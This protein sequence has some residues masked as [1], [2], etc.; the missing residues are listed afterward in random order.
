MPHRITYSAVYG[1]ALE[2]RTADEDDVV[3]DRI[4]RRTGWFG[5]VALDAE[6]PHV[7][8]ILVSSYGRKDDPA[9][10]GPGNWR[11][12]VHF[13]WPALKGDATRFAFRLCTEQVDRDAATIAGIVGFPVELDAGDLAAVATIEFW[14]SEDPGGVVSWPASPALTYGELL[15]IVTDLDAYLRSAGEAALW[16]SSEIQ[17]VPLPHSVRRGRKVFLC[18]SSRDKPFAR[19]LARALR[20]AEVE[21]WFD[22]DEILVGHDFVERMQEGL[23]EARFVVVILSPNLSEGGPWAREELRHA[24]E[25]QVREGDVVLLPVLLEDCEIPPL[26]RSKT[27]ADFRGGF[28]AGFERLVHSITA[29]A[30]RSG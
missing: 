10:R 23:R 17:P 22:E 9:G 30:R 5:T 27:Y 2:T 18:H 26:M 12:G 15:S 8:T 24:L 28:E 14:Y 25:Q 21:V 16:M 13:Q 11:I 7:A 19:E 20:E 29:H 3:I 1:Q 6:L 4:L